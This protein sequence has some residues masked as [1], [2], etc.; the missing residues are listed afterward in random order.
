MNILINFQKSSSHEPRSGMDW[1]LVWNILGA[2]IFKLFKWS[3]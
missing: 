1:Y 2:R 3:P